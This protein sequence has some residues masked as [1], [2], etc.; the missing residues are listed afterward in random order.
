MK[1]VATVEQARGLISSTKLLC[2]KG[3][4][5]LHKF[6][7]NNSEVL[8]SIPPEDR[9]AD[10]RNPSLVSNDPAIERALGVHW[11]I[12]SD[13]LQFRIELKDKP[14]SR[15]GILSTVSSIYDPL[16]L[17]APV[18]LQGKRILQELC[19]DGVGWD[20]KVPEDIR[21]R[22]ERWRSELPALEKLKV[23]RCHKPNEYKEIKTVELHHFSD[24]SQNGYGQC[25]YLR[26]TDSN[27]RICCSLVMGKSRV[28]PLKPVTIP[29]LELTAAVVASK[30]GCVLRKELEY[31]EVKETYWTDSKTV[32]GYISNDARR[33]HVF[34]GNR[35]QEIRDK[36]SPEQWHY[37][38][39][40][41]N[42]ADV[43]SRGSS[44]Q[45][46]I[47]NS[48]WW[49]GPELLWKPD[50]DWNLTDASSEI[51]PDDPEVKRGSVLA[52]QVRKPPSVLERLEYFSSWHRAKKA[53][54]VCLRLQEK[55]RRANDK[56]V[57]QDSSDSRSSK[58][59][60][61][62]VEELQN[63]E[64]EIIK[65]VQKAAFPEEISSMKK[66][67]VREQTSGEKT[68]TYESRAMKKASSLYQLDP[69]LDANEILRVGGRIRCSSLSYS[70]KHPIIL[71]RKGHVTELIICHHH[72]R[73]EHQGRGMTH[74][75]IR[76]AGYWVIGGSSAVSN[77]IAQC[78]KCRKLRGTP[79]DQ[80]MADLPED[81]LEP[82]P[83][84][85]LS[86][87]DYFGPWY[88]KEGRKELKRYGV[89]LTCLSSRAIHLEVS[90]SLA[91][92]SF[93]NAYR[94]FVGR[95]GPVRQLRS[96]Q[97]TNFIGAMN[98]LQQAVKELNH[99]RIR[100]ELLLNNCDWIEFKPNVPHASH[101]GGVWERQ[102][103]SVRNVLASLLES[104][105]TQLDDESLRTFMVEAEAIVNCRPLAVNTINSSQNPE[106]LTP[107]HLLTMKSKVIMPPPGDFQ[108]ADLYLSKRWRRVQYLANEFWNR[109]KKEFLQSLQPRQKWIAVRRNLQV[110][111]VVI[112]MD[113]SL[114]RNRWK[115]ARVHETFPN[116]DGLVRKVKMAIATESLDDS[117]RPTKPT[118]YLERPVQKVVLVLPSDQVADQGI[119][120]KEP[121]L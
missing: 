94:R 16:G 110:N 61:V 5:H 57:K 48:L 116:D 88:V 72:Q 120:T 71:P 109:W 98:E 74:N 8:N 95:R 20:D 27:D 115:L 107:N 21:P 22:W 41:E 50:K 38:G 75:E 33:F 2:Q 113:E 92:D 96:D 70:T 15:R 105:G 68:I 87:V 93:L 66:L 39:T 58:Y 69:F 80:K 31:E 34:V 53:V 76:S 49:N 14:L 44:V 55:F 60:P 67:N 99:E 45:E 86:A 30:I 40:K 104:H 84:F 108:R 12:E 26:L 13:T 83:P 90:N 51:S 18:I 64:S 62:N 97:G 81:R 101:M 35:V 118:V 25:S 10:K 52:T 29:R 112:V 117:G 114:P 19:R 56:E 77:H 46:L 47:D 43:A 3:G 1:S 54:A 36:T 24:A 23:P 59:I 6:T 121:Q 106:P 85:T 7:S 82:A 32:L 17:V 73:V 65:I 42:P 79:Q 111:D 37:I 9:A 100:E 78:V 89:L 28:T 102:I 63:A 119:P 91:T 103:R 11:C 4:F